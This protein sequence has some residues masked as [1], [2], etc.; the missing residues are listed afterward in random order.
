[1]SLSGLGAD[2]TAFSRTVYTV[3]FD[4]NVR[5][6]RAP[7]VYPF[8]I[9]IAKNR[10]TTVDLTP[11]LRDTAWG[12]RH[13]AIVKISSTMNIVRKYRDTPYIAIVVLRPLKTITPLR[14]GQGVTYSMPLCN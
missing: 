12:A 3:T 13:C 4:F 14:R 7:Y 9:I 6:I 1:V 10:Y 2:S 11:S 5:V 8:T